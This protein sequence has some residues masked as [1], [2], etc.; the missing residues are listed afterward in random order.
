MGKRYLLVV[1][2]VVLLMVVSTGPAWAQYGDPFA[3]LE[4]AVI[5]GCPFDCDSVTLRLTGELTSTSWKAPVLTGWNRVGD[6]I[7]V[8]VDVEFAGDLALPVTVPFELLAPLGPLPQGAYRVVYVIS[9]IGPATMPSIP[10]VVTDGFRVAPP[11]DQNCDGVV[12]IWDVIRSVDYVFRG[13][14]PPDPWRR[15]DLNCDGTIDVFDVIALIVH[16]FYGGDIWDP[17]AGI[18]PSPVGQV[19]AFSDCKGMLKTATASDVSSDQDCIEHDYDGDSVLVLKHV[20]AAFNCC[21]DSFTVAFDFAGRSITIAEIE[22]LT[23]PC[24]CLCLYDV[25]LRITGL[26]AGTWTITVVEPYLWPG[27][28]PLTFTLDLVVSPSGKYCVTRDLYPWGE[29]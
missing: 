29:P 10:I 1:A 12:D 22:W 7:T 8:F 15:G 13:G 9:V 28:E 21:P 23:T 18:S 24:K 20:N 14:P 2:P 19:V 4:Y 27:A 5:P 6:S 16:V 25:D 3:H 26:P 11:G 17:C